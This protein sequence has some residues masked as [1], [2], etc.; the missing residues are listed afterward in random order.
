MGASVPNLLNLPECRIITVDDTDD[1]YHIAV[2]TLTVPTMCPH[3]QF[4]T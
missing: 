1:A 4:F 3:V 2:E